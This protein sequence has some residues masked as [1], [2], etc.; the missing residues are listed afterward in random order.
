MQS[1]GSDGSGRATTGSTSTV[2]RRP[3]STW[4]SGLGWGITWDNASSPTQCSAFFD[5]PNEGA[6]YSIQHLSKKYLLG[7]GWNGVGYPDAEI[8]QFVDNATP[9]PKTF[10]GIDRGGDHYGSAAYNAEW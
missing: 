9:R 6:E 10:C 1:L 7:E 2:S 3:S 8:F 5:E 4:P